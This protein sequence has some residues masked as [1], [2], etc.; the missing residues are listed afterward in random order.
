MSMYNLIQYSDN[1]SDTSESL[2]QFKRDEQPINNNGA[3]VNITAENSSSFKYK[4][5]LIG[6][7][8][9]DGTN[10]KKENVKIVAPLKYL[11]N[12]WRSLEMP[13]INCKVEFSLKWYEECILPTSG[14]AATFKINDTK[15]YV[16]V[17][18]LK[19]ENNTKLSRLLSEGFKRPIYWNEYK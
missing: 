19:T 10:R 14:T 5:N 12:F 4:S 3:F 7:T 8:V 16:P 18:T 13:L 11:S 9:A 1:Y 15:R 6:H 17:V 2:W